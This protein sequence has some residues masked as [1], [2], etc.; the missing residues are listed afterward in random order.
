[1][2]IKKERVELCN[3]LSTMIGQS[4]KARMV[5]KCVNDKEGIN[6]LREIQSRLQEL[7]DSL[8][9]SRS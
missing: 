3:I 6:K 2:S 4:I 8:M 9:P 5:T 1:M 7:Y